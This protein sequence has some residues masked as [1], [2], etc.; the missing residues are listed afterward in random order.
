MSLIRLNIDLTNVGQL[1]ACFGFLEIADRMWGKEAGIF[2]RFE[3]NPDTFIVNGLRPIKDIL[4]WLKNIQVRDV[5]VKEVN[6]KG[7]K[8]TKRATIEYKG[9]ADDPAILQMS[10]KEEWVIDNWRVTGDGRPKIKTFSGKMKAPIVIAY[11]LKCLEELEA[12]DFENL[13]DWSPVQTDVAVFSFDGR[14]GKSALDI[15]FSP[16]SL[17]MKTQIFP[18]VELFA[19]IGLQYVRPMPVGQSFQV[20]LWTQPLPA[21]LARAVASLA[22]NVPGLRRRQFRLIGRKERSGVSNAK[23][24][25]YQTFTQA[26]EVMEREDSNDY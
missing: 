6:S 13:F 9:K 1:L 16:D 23:N 18:A 10:E 7:R 15:G 3:F 20:G 14:K 19:A 4:D 26:F 5:I 22:F 11:L 8:K 21:E 12:S 24:D 2:G 17:K 25:Q